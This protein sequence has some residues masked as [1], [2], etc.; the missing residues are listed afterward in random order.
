MPFQH[1]Y[2]TPGVISICSL[3]HSIFQ[4]KL[5][6]QKE[7]ESPG[8]EALLHYFVCHDSHSAA[9][10]SHLPFWEANA[11]TKQRT[12]FLIF[13][14][15]LLPLASKA[16]WER[17]VSTN[18]WLLPR[19]TAHYNIHSCTKTCNSEQHGKQQDHK[20]PNI[21]SSLLYNMGAVEIQDISNSSSICSDIT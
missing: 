15:V 4:S 18:C 8:K 5:S 11:L 21:S 12:L 14:G 20:W 13:V 6:F 1:N 19:D 3:R 16:F 17:V 10:H 9:W 2:F 7:V